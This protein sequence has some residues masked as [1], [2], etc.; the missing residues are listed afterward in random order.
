MALGLVRSLADRP[1][2][3]LPGEGRPV[4]LVGSPFRPIKDAMAKEKA[5]RV[6]R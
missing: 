4:F 1:V 6:Q 2:G 5:K 3:S